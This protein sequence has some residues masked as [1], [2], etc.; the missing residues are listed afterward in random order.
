MSRNGAFFNAK[1]L[2]IGKSLQKVLISGK[3]R[4]NSFL[5]FAHLISLCIDDFIKTA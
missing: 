5:R 2:N 1:P 3:Y 4:M